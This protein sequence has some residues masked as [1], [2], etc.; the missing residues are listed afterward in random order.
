MTVIARQLRKQFDRDLE[1]IGVTR[2][3]WTAI[4]VVVSRPG[5]TQR[6]LAEALDMS[7]AAAGRLVDRLCAEGLLERHAKEGDKRAY[8]IS[9][10][11]TAVPILERGSALA[12]RLEEHAFRGMDDGEIRQ[13]SSLLDRLYDNINRQGLPESD[14]AG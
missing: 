12:A 1:G 11:E 7:E 8:C 5:A 2:S 6:V 4:V 3:R 10:T 14:A 9:L 13:L